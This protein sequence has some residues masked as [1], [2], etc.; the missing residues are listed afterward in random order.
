MPGSAH[1]IAAVAAVLVLVLCGATPAQAAPSHAEITG[2]GSSW[3][4]NAVNQWISDVSKNGLQVVYTSAGSAT[5]RQ[6]FADVS[7]DFAVSDIPY[8]GTDPETGLQDTSMGRQYA[9]LPIVAGGTSFPYHLG[10][11]ANQI[12][13][14]RLSGKTLAEIF[15]N[16]ITNWDDPQIAADNNHQLHL[17]NLPIIPVVHAEGSGDTA[18]FSQYLEADYPS[19]WNPYNQVDSFTEYWPRKGAQV[20]QNGSDGVMNFIASGAG[21]GTIG[22]DEYSYPLLSGF[23]VAKLE[24]SAG[25]FTAPTQ[26]NVAVALTQAKINEDKTSI[27]YLTQTLTNVYTYSDPRTY[28]LSSYSYAIIPTGNNTQETHTNTTAKRQTIAD[29]LYN[30]ICQGQQEI[31]PI[32]YSAL[33]VNLVEAGFDQIAKLNAADPGVDLNKENVSTCHNPTFI[34]G[35]P[36]V[37][38]LAVIAPKP[39]ACDKINAGPCAAGVG[40]ANANPVN[41]KAP[42]NPNSAAGGQS[43]AAAGA[44]ASA[45][46][47]VDPNTGQLVTAGTNSGPSA[48]GAAAEGVATNLAETADS[49]PLDSVLGVLAVALLLAVLVVP[50]VLTRYLAGRRA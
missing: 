9:Y 50:P 37:N 7:T 33:P 16:K 32:G 13:N 25:Y 24:N 43:S 47:S 44:S 19:L 29:F 36:N 14:L 12:K 5:G 2:S 35:Q 22:Y 18:Q 46:A 17:P 49:S 39:P 45:S 23:P 6:Q 28:P 10:N 41:G 20:A 27:N 15:T 40:L 26:Y 34:P 8:Q 30:S 11:G 3:A 31:G 21:N 38:H 42:V 1:R 48:S 4:A